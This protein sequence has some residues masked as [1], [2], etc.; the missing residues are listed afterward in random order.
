[1]ANRTR[2]C[3]FFIRLN[4]LIAIIS[5]SSRSVTDVL[6]EVVGCLFFFV[7]FFV[8]FF[9]IFGNSDLIDFLF[10]FLP[11]LPEMLLTEHN[12]QPH[13]WPYTFFLTALGFQRSVS[14]GAS[15]LVLSWTF[16]L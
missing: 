11:G 15:R 9:F 12:H 2:W 6:Y 7:L 8:A 1:M 16:L 4:L 13:T 3:F 5:L 10:S 14:R